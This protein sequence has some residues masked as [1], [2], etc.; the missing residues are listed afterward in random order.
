MMALITQLYPALRVDG[1]T[2]SGFSQVFQWEGAWHSIGLS[3]GSA[4]ATATSHA[5]YLLYSPSFI[6]ET[7]FG[8][9]IEL[10]LSPMLAIPHVA[11]AIGF[12]FLF[13]PTRSR[14]E[15]TMCVFN[16]VNPRPVRVS[17]TRK[18]RMHLAWSLCWRLKKCLSLICSIS[19]LQQIDV[20]RITKV[21]A[22]LGYGRSWDMVESAFSHN[23]SPSFAS[24]CWRCSLTAYRLSILR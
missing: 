24:Q 3:L 13:S 23:G 8:E 12:A 18:I 19:I 5:S 4:I 16:L 21:S 17:V 22:S 11:F 20:E 6:G 1:A 7:D 15:N 10:T 2:L 9:K 14:S